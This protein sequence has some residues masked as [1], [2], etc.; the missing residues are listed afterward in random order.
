MVFAV[1]VGSAFAQDVVLEDFTG[2]TGSWFVSEGTGL[3][4]DPPVPFDGRAL[5]CTPVAGSDLCSL[6][7]STRFPITHDTVQLQVSTDD[8]PSFGLHIQH[9]R[10]N[11][12]SP[13]RHGP[14]PRRRAADP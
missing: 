1:L 3:F 7:S 9:E 2:P 4:L 10:R 8:P 5:Q 11:S 12:A 6:F 14:R 13:V